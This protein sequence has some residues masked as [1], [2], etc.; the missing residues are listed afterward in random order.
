MEINEIKL[1]STGL[2]KFVQESLGGRTIISDGLGHNFAL[3]FG[4]N[5]VDTEALVGRVADFYT[6]R[7]YVQPDSAHLSFANEDKKRDIFLTIK[8]SFVYVD[9]SA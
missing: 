9:I 4:G 6:S 8:P 3:D 5:V 7:G 1:E 2:A